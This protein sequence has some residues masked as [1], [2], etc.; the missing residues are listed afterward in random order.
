VIVMYGGRIVE[1]AEVT[2]LFDDPQHPYSWGLLGSVPRIDRPRTVR[3][4]TISGAPPSLLRPPAGCHFSP[5]CPHRFASCGEVPPL[6]ARTPGQ[7][8][9][10]D[11]CWLTVDEKRRLR[12]IDGEIGLTSSDA[13]VIA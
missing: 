8:H 7:P 9:H 12:S 13:A 5:R 10:R 6:Q 3:L 11:R 1:Q 2:E 4:P